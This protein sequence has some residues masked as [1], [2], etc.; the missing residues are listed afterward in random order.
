MIRRLYHIA[1]SFYTVAIRIAAVAGHQK[2]KLWVDGRKA[3]FRNLEQ[4]THSKTAWFHCASLGEFEQGRP[5]IEAFRQKYPDYRVVL[6]FF[7]PSGYEV[8]KN[9][10]SADVVTYLP[11]DTPANA[12][13]F[14]RMVQ[15]D[16][17]FFV[18]YEFWFNYLSELKK[19]RIPVYLV[20]GIFR[21]QQ[22]FFRWYG[23]WFRKQLKAFDKFFVQNE[24]SYTLI[25]ALFPGKS[26]ITG[27]TRF[28]RV[29]DIAKK[30]K[31][32]Q[33]I[34]DFKNGRLLFIAGSTW[35][36][37]EEMMLPALAAHIESGKIKL[38]VAPHEV[39]HTRI[40]ALMDKLPG[41]AVRY[42]DKPPELPEADILVIDSIGILS[43][44]YQY[45]DIA[46]IG[47]GFGVGIH[48]TLEAA[49]FGLP[50]IFGPNY[51]KFQEAVDLIDE[52]AAFAVDSRQA[53]RKI[54]EEMLQAE[55]YRHKAGEKAREFVFR[56]KGGTSRILE[57]IM[58]R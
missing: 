10:P 11:A 22:H 16:I 9:Y 47:G 46:Y 57:N 55:D 24:A 25:N 30:A 3:V 33:D 4:G 38:I 2:A 28:D 52:G 49:T 39:G 34:A 50:V 7:S 58:L 32:F 48:N 13:R 31:P 51:H 19:R 14:I 21:K 8:K 43:H 29:Y 6:T 54:V 17:A 1:V 36:A 45:G 20:S 26:L 42:S 44:L 12:R 23:G 5:L 35:P 41:K 27:D 37:D 53:F 15:P 56:N 18:K 40:N